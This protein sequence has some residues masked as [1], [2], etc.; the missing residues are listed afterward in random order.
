MNIN[1]APEICR[2]EDYVA[3]KIYEV[4][5]TR[6]QKNAWPD[7][8]DWPQ[9]LAAAGYENKPESYRLDNLKDYVGINAD[10]GELVWFERMAWENSPVFVEYS[11]FRN[12]KL[13]YEGATP[14]DFIWVEIN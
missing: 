12:G 8:K 7:A 14:T 5:G 11:T 6:L 10:R 9:F 4:T 2:S 3:R 1:K 13:V